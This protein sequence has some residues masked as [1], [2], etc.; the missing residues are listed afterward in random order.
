MTVRDSFVAHFGEENALA[1]EAAAEEHENGMHPN[2]G[3]DPFQWT[4]MLVLSYECASKPRYA[5]YHGITAPW[6]K[7]DAWIIEHGH[8]A[9]YDGDIDALALFTKT[10]DRYVEVANGDSG[11]GNK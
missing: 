1:F 8:M 4:L 3:S 9:D 7:V 2:K 5:K 11:E 10:Y 6:D